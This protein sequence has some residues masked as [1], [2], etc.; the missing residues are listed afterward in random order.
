LAIVGVRPQFILTKA[1][2]EAKSTLNRAQKLAIPIAS[3]EWAIQRLITG[4]KY[5]PSFHAAFQILTSDAT[6]HNI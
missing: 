6:E 5:Q 4:I 1:G 2:C 3:P